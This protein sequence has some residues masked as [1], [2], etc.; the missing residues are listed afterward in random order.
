MWVG[1]C[2]RRGALLVGMIEVAGWGDAGELCAGLGGPLGMPVLK[3]CS[4]RLQRKVHPGVS[5]IVL[6]QRERGPCTPA[7]R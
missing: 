3:C 6:S 4:T 2:G 7:G 5:A 1:R